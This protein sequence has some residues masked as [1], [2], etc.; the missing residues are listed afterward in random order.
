M[1][2]LEKWY[3]YNYLQGRNRKVDVENGC[4]D[5]GEG[6]CGMNWEIRFDINR[7][8]MCKIDS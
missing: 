3:R 5:T 2:N 1:W 7:L 4:V 6:E 8:T